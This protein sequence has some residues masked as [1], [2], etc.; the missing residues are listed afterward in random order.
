[1][2]AR[3]AIPDTSLFRYLNVRKEAMLSSMIKGTQSSLSD[4]LL[5]VLDREQGVPLD[6]VRTVS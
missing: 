3:Q 1:M 5:F 6:N 4:L 2:G